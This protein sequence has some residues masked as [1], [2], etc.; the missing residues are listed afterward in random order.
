MALSVPESNNGVGELN[1]QATITINIIPTGIE[2]TGNN[3][4]I[5]VYP[6]PVYDE[7]IIEIEGNK[8]RKDYEILNSIGNIVFK[9]NLSER[10][11]VSTSNF[12]AHSLMWKDRPFFLVPT[13][14]GQEILLITP[15]HIALQMRICANY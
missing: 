13:W 10:T 6:N 5:K 1:R 12:S 15:R 7:L 8:D 4:E 14:Q 3:S 9:G 2:L 11:L